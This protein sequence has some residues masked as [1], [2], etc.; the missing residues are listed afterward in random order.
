MRE[1][2][3]VYF[4]EGETDA[5]TLLD[6]GLENDPKVAVA[7]APSASTFE[8]QWA[9]MF[10]GK[11]VV[12]CYDADLAGEKGIARVGPLIAAEAKSVNVWNPKEVR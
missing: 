3:T 12:L 7:S 6:L 9:E 11:D 5:I 4:A 2:S 1:A 10:R 8:K